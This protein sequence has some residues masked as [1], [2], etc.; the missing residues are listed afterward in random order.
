MRVLVIE[1]QADIRDTLR[2]ILE[3]NGHEVLTAADGVA[4]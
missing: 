1:D 3:F 4:D 2:D